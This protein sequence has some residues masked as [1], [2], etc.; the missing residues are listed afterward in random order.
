MSDKLE[1]VKNLIMYV[2]ENENLVVFGS[3]EHI[4]IINLFEDINH[5]EDIKNTNN[6]VIDK[7]IEFIKDNKKLL[8]ILNNDIKIDIDAI[9]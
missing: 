9:K 2:I 8:S 4:K 5:L 1:Q 6:T 3:D 7:A